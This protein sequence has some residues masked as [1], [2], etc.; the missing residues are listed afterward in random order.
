MRILAMDLGKNKSV[1]CDYD[2]ESGR[3]KFLTIRTRPQEVHDLLVEREPDRVVLETGAS[4]GW[5]YDLATALGLQVQVATQQPPKA[6]LGIRI[7]IGP[8]PAA[9]LCAGILFAFL[10][11]LGRERHA[12]IVQELESRRKVRSSLEG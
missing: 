11:P 2:S 3:H 1:V 4:S 6:L 7:V 5:V 8:I 9:L 10:Y 12:Q